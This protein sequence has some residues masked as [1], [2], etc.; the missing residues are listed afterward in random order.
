M[1]IIITG[2]TSFLGAAVAHRLL[3]AGHE[4]I[5]VLRPDSRK[6][7]NFIDENRRAFQERR[8]FVVE[9]DISEPE[10][11]PEKTE[12][13][14]KPGSGPVFCHFGWEGS[15]SAARTDMELQQKNLDCAMRTLKVASEL[16]CSRFIFA[17][18]QAEY[19]RHTHMVTETS[20]CS[21]TSAYGRAK[22]SMSSE[23]EALAKILGIRYIHTRIFSVYGRGDH[24]WTL[25]ESC[26]DAFLADKD[27]DLGP[28]TQ[29]WNFLNIEDLADAFKSLI[30]VSD[31]TLEKADDPIFNV[32][33]TDTR[34]LKD[35]V[36]EIHDLCGGRGVCHYGARD[37]NA[38]GYVNL[39]PSIEKITRVT[40]WKPRVDFE[41]G[42]SQMIEYK[43]FMNQ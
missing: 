6:R 37:D 30:E 41:S 13:M 3:E 18:S 26:L 28:C 39:D 19:G 35:F 7:N 24:P 22:L 32:A 38:E 8:L 5:A 40:K 1:Q 21:P 33:G 12:A 17:G 31:E 10:A 42:I 23:G 20:S 25:V 36:E 11:L 15:G 29:L 16:N 14:I 43:K 27:I 9:N 2:A 34:P 4:V